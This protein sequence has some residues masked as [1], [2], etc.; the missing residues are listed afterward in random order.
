[1]ISGSP[2]LGERLAGVAFVGGRIIIIIMIIM[3]IITIITLILIA[4]IIVMIIVVMIVIGAI[5]RA[6]RHGGR[7]LAPR[8]KGSG[9]A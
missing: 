3:I 2:V 6:A 7:P 5:G 1:M 9:V 8:R 4:I